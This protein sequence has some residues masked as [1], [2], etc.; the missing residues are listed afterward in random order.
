[1]SETL[2][3]PDSIS[4]KSI[5]SVLLVC[6]KFKNEFKECVSSGYVNNKSKNIQ[7]KKV[8]KKYKDCG[9]LSCYRCKHWYENRPENTWYKKVLYHEVDVPDTI[10]M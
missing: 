7:N 2:E 3:I 5:R 8:L 6:D 10:N 9:K 1:M 4:E